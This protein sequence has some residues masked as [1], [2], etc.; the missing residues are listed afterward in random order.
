MYVGLGSVKR[1][2]CPLVF[3]RHHVSTGDDNRLLPYEVLIN[4]LFPKVT[5]LTCVFLSRNSQRT[6]CVRPLIKRLV[7]G[8]QGMVKHI[9]EQNN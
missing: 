9:R 4:L 3:H 6:V 1:R 2:V 5:S 8:L 7:D